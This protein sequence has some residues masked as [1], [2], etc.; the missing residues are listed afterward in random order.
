MLPRLV[1]LFLCAAL[2]T[3]TH[4]ASAKIQ[5][6]V[7]GW[8]TLPFPFSE[9]V[10]HC[11]SC[12]QNAQPGLNEACTL[13][14][15]GNQ[16]FDFTA[17]PPAMV[18]GGIANQTKYAL[19]D[20]QSIVKA[21]NATMDDITSCTVWLRSIG[22]FEAMNDVYKAAFSEPYPTRA[23]AGG[24]DLAGKDALVEIA[25]EALAPCPYA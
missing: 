15:S 18:P 2:A 20:I 21:A 19:K 14:I 17:K 25:C 10:L 22:D 4:A 11:T 16:G 13:K 1:L 8:P 5:V 12:S 7:P 3:R 9:G 6:K 23:A 24:Y